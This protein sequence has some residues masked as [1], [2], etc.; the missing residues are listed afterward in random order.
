MTRV[1]VDTDLPVTIAPGAEGTII[2]LIS[3]SLLAVLSLRVGVL[4]WRSRGS[5]GRPRAMLWQ[6]FALAGLFGLLAGSVEITARVT[7]TA[8]PLSRPLLFGF[9]LVLAVAIR[10]AYSQTE[11]QT[12]TASERRWIVETAAVSGIIVVGVGIELG[13]S[14][15][16]DVLLAGGGLFAASYGVYFQRKRIGT[17]A[18]RGTLIDTLLRQ[19]LPALVFASSAVVTPMLGYGILGP[20]LTDLITSVFV[21]LVGAALLPVT[22]KLRQHLLTAA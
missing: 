19:A 11:A 10:E 9:A 1:G 6:Y 5:A 18:T 15:V 22:V 17:K 20:E 8:V 21:L 13:T 16:A 4:S 2:A 12:A 3:Y 7:G 14:V